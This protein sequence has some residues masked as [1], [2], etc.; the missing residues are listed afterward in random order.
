MSKTR[1]RE[2]IRRCITCKH[3]YNPGDRFITPSSTKGFWEYDT[4]TKS[5]C[6][7]TRMDRNAE[8]G[9]CSRYESRF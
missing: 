5:K 3:W 6:L 1:I 2:N 8:H 4:Q 9:V 7:I